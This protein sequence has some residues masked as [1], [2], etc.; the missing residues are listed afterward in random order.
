M[1][2]SGLSARIETRSDTERYQDM[3]YDHEQL[4]ILNLNLQGPQPGFPGLGGNRPFAR[5]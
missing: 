1:R 4:I 5:Y 2:N 3:D